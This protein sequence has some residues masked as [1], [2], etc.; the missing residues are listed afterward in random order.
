MIAG[1]GTGLEFGEQSPSARAGAALGGRAAGGEPRPG[2][3]RP[4][5]GL[6]GH[7]VGVCCSIAP[8]G[9]GA[10]LSPAPMPASV[11][12]L[13]CDLHTSVYVG[14]KLLQEPLCECLLRVSELRSTTL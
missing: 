14:L 10:V 6:G 3:A 9:V 5:V 2:G 1:G 4:G 12:G 11:G 13:S 7:G 8:V